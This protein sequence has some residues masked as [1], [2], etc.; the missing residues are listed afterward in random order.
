ML[1]T[2]FTPGDVI[3]GRYRLESLLGAG[4]MGS[5][6]RA[7]H[8]MLKSPVALKFIDPTIASSEAAVA[9]FVRE[10]QSAAALRS[11]HVVQ[12]FDYGVEQSVPY[13]VMELL[14]GETLRD[15][16]DHQGPLLP[17]D[18]ARIMSQVAR[19]V[20]KAH[21]AGIV[22]RDLKPE[23]I[24]LVSE[25]EH[26][27]VKVLDFG[28]AKVSD[29]STGTTSN[30]TRT[31]AI[32]GTPYYMSPEQAQGNKAVDH[33]T[34][35]WALGVITYECVVGARPFDS[36]GLGELILRI[37]AEPLPVPSQ[38]ARVPPSFDAWFQ[39]AASRSPDGRFSSAKELIETLR[40]ALGVTLRDS[41]G[42]PA[43]AGMADRVSGVPAITASGAVPTPV[44]ATWGMTTNQA[45]IAA[46]P[47]IPIKKSNPLPL[48]L[49][50][51]VG[52]FVLLGVG[53]FAVVQIKRS[54]AASAPSAATAEMAATSAAEPPPAAPSAEPTP[55][56][57]PAPEP[58][59]SVEPE[60]PKAAASKAAPTPAVKAKPGG[61]KSK[62]PEPAKPSETKP[63]PAAT[64]GAFDD[65]KG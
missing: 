52:A 32:L 39:R 44:G 53:G 34:D 49:G 51:A 14:T 45:A 25:D 36:D 19:A 42:P 4:G 43:L 41:D 55:P 26:E 50:I 6:W 56:P 57:E 33:R 62:P 65:R 21:D 48:L 2:N 7:D 64:T 10:A 61:T 46:A 23:N 63:K 35:L 9:R 27:V 29:R 15:R 3:A 1:P 24:F 37:C 18:T 13:I 8:L 31:G 16:L 5:V 11:T 47:A 17:R 22:H 54:A 28:I 58:S 59:A 60:A 40:M 12:I 38:H 30:A 20:G